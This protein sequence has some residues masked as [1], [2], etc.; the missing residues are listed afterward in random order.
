[1]LQDTMDHS[2]SELLSRIT[3][4]PAL[5]CKWSLDDLWKYVSLARHIRP[6]IETLLR[7][8]QAG[9]PDR[10]SLQIHNFLKLSMGLEDEVA[11]QAWGVLKDVIWDDPS[12]QDCVGT[13]SMYLSSSPCGRSRCSSSLARIGE[14]LRDFVDFG[15]PYG[16]GMFV[17]ILTSLPH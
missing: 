2:L 11:K 6:D 8:N 16:V 15:V 4:I 10:L 9:P 5:A 7:T 3:S 12:L 17:S 14:Y 1:M 13:R